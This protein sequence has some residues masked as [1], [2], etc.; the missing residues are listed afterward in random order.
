MISKL[1]LVLVL[2]FVY[3]NIIFLVVLSTFSTSK[4]KTIN[5]YYLQYFSHA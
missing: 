3:F 2:V 1:L 4:F 5:Y